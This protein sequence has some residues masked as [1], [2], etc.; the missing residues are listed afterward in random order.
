MNK[1]LCVCMA[2]LLLVPLCACKAQPPTQ[3]GFEP[4][5][6]SFPPGVQA[7]KE[8]LLT[9][10]IECVAYDEDNTSFA[11]ALHLLVVDQPG[12]SLVLMAIPSDTRAQI[13]VF[14]GEQSAQAQGKIRHAYTTAEGSGLAEQNTFKAVTTLLGGVQL[15]GYITLNSKQLQ[16]L[17]T[18][19]GPIQVFLDAE[20]ANP[21]GFTTGDAII[22]DGAVNF[23]SFSNLLSDVSGEL[24]PGTDLTKLDR[25]QRLI[26]AC[27][28]AYAAGRADD[29]A[30]LGTILDATHMRTNLGSDALDTVFMAAAQIDQAKRSKKTLPGQDSIESGE[31]T[32][33]PDQAQ[34]SAWVIQTFYQRS[35]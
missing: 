26:L 10:L 1:I 17:A 21:F 16:L 34:I 23:A 33:I 8:G 2:L 22:N 28:D 24:T 13:S 32:F 25:Q 12:Q 27:I 29:S 14:H 3:D 30:L 4:Y 15:D 5:A 18:T 31:N 9:L 35:A 19:L 20:Y 6:Y 7:K 11:S